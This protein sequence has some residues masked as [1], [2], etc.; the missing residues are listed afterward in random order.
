MWELGSELAFT[1]LEWDLEVVWDLWKL[2]E[3]PEARLD[4][5]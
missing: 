3:H 5:R 2:D 1:A 4:I